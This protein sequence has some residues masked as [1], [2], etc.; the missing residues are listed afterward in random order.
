[1]VI[2]SS[3]YYPSITINYGVVNDSPT[4]SPTIT[5]MPT[6]PFPTA[7]PTTAPPTNSPTENPTNSPTVSLAPTPFEPIK[8]TVATPPT[9][10]ASTA[11]A[12]YFDVAGGVNDSVITNMKVTTY[13]PSQTIKVFAKRGNAAGSEAI[14]CDWQLVAETGN[15]STG[16]W[17]TIYPKWINGFKPVELFAGETVSF[18][19]QT[20]KSL[21][22]KSASSSLKYTNYMT[23]DSA[24]VLPGTGISY[25]AT[26]TNNLF[27]AH[28]SYY[29]ARYVSFAVSLIHSSAKKYC[30]EVTHLLFILTFSDH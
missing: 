21:L 27:E 17:K 3:P 28:P 16:Y 11:N 18:Y 10:S 29:S 7:A 19:V 15:E 8:V 2:Q 23:T 25:A 22:G 26:G 12:F 24:H 6:T 1:M 4:G 13:A 20:D 5:A 30:P 14:P 9:N